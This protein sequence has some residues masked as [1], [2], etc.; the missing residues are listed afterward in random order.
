[1]ER[2]EQKVTPPS[3]GTQEAAQELHNPFRDPL[4]EEPDDPEQEAEDEAAAE[5][6]KKEAMTERD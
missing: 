6:Q 3:K 4:P 5:Q 1:M 2:D